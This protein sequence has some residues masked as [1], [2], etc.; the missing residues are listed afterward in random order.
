MYTDF[1]PIFSST[2][3]TANNNLD[4]GIGSNLKYESLEA[5]E[6]WRPCS[7]CSRGRVALLDILKTW[8]KSYYGFKDI[9]TPF[10]SFEKN[11]KIHQN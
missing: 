2:G 3:W 7:G 8:G 9:R 4:F 1:P 10:S 11:A 5:A 6:R